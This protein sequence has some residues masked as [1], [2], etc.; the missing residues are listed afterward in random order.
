MYLCVSL[1]RGIEK[2]D[3]LIR[4]EL[5]QSFLHLLLLLFAARASP[6][7]PFLPPLLLLLLFFS[8]SS[9]PLGSGGVLKIVV[10]P[11][12]GLIGIFGPLFISS[13]ATRQSE[14]DRG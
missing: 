1:H 8:P 11:F 6:S 12:D 3:S 14:G 5:S 13:S 9:A 10:L 4:C 7:L 2:E